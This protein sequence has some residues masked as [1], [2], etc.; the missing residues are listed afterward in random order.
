MN[1]PQPTTMAMPASATASG[2]WLQTI[3]PTR[4]AKGTEAK[5]KGATAEVSAVR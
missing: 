2:A 1:R 4:M 3:Q 5:R